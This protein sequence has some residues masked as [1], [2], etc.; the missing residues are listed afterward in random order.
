MIKAG[1]YLGAL[2]GIPLAVKDVFDVAGLSTTGGSVTLGENVADED[3]TAV[4]RLSE[5][6]MITLGKTVTVEFARGIVGINH[7]QGTPHN[8]WS[9]QHHVPGGSSAGSA[10]AVAAGLAP[11]ALGSDTGG[12]VR[13]PAALC[14]IVGLKTTV[15]RI[16][17]HGVFPVSW[18][19]D[20][21]GPL[22]RTVEDAALAYLVMIGSDP[23][24]ETTMGI[25]FERNLPS[26]R[27]GV[28]GLR[29][30]IPNGLF[31]DDLDAEVDGALA[32][33]RRKFETL[34]AHVVELDFPEAIAG[35][36]LGAVIS[37][38]EAC[39]THEAR[40]ESQ[41]DDMD[42]IVGPRM[43]VDRTITAVNY[44]KALQSMQELRRS[45]A[46]TLRDIDLLLVP[47]T[48]IPAHPISSVDADLASHDRYA[49]IYARN[50]R[51]GNILNL[52]GLAMPCGAT[53]SG[54]PIGLTL[55]GKPFA[56]ELVLRAGFAYEKATEWHRLRPNLS[57]MH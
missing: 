9:E 57:K 27:A 4:R 45:A 8:P 12:S 5:A 20:T 23:N 52:C 3:S 49:K 53:T 47:T 55:Y 43:L 40:L 25:P 16:G 28:G 6:G 26:L 38:A 17:R 13:T 48:P 29:I 14:G 42:T 10:V 44:I 22:A 7:I 36:A 30:G 31:F 39:V 46:Q 51:V 54:L 37:G 24:D 33:A 50:C 15:G 21:V 32:E 35:E 34:G 41:V 11:I 18:T 56:E 2:H 19:L 1:R